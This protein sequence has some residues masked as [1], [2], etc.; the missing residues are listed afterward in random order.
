MLPFC[1]SNVQVTVAFYLFKFLI[2]AYDDRKVRSFRGTGCQSLKKFK[3]I[4]TPTYDDR[5]AKIALWNDPLGRYPALGLTSSV[6]CVITEP[7][8]CIVIYH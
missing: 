7:A 3:I 1:F 4:I 6:N 2:L 5:R 8:N